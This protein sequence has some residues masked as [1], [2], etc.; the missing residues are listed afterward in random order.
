[1]SCCQGNSDTHME[2]ARCIRDSAD[3]PE[4][5]CIQKLSIVDPDYPHNWNGPASQVQVCFVYVNP[6]LTRPYI[7]GD[8]SEYCSHESVYLPR[9]FIP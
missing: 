3:D 4:N 1:M 8:N 6:A 2:E 7:K 9:E 5:E